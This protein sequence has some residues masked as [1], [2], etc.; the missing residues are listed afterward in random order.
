MD[1]LRDIWGHYYFLRTLHLP[2]KLFALS[3]SIIYNWNWFHLY[4]LKK[5]LEVFVRL[6][7]WFIVFSAFE[8][9]HEWTFWEIY[10][11]IIICWGHYTYLPNGLPYGN[12]IF[13]IEIVFIVEVFKTFLRFS[14]DWIQDL[15]F[16][17]H[18]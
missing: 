6:D 8:M 4:T 3:K 15:L 12:L 10:Q 9:P 17:L 2:T 1:F 13:R 16:F 18:L 5:V 11:V 7:P 14:F